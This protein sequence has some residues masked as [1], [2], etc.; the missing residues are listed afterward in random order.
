MAPVGFGFFFGTIS[1]G[2]KKPPVKF[3]ELQN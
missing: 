2:M 1:I 3:S